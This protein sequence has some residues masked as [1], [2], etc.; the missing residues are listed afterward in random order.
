[1]SDQA[2]CPECQHC[3]IV[4]LE[5]SLGQGESA[6]FYRCT[7][8]DQEWLALQGIDETASIERPSAPQARHVR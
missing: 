2:T 1:V 3:G 6:I 5:H 7:A 4:A 8:C